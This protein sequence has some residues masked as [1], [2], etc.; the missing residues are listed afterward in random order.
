MLLAALVFLLTYSQAFIAEAG[1]TNNVNDLRCVPYVPEDVGICKEVLEFSEGT[2]I[3]IQGD[4]SWDFLVNR[5]SSLSSLGNVFSMPD[6]CKELATLAGCITHFRPCVLHPETETAI[7]WPVRP[8]RS[9]C[10]DYLQ[11]CR[12]FLEEMEI[13]SSLSIFTPEGFEPYNTTCNEVDI[14]ASNTSFFSATANYTTTSPFGEFTLSCAK[15]LGKGAFSL[16]CEDPLISIEGGC[17]FDCPLPSLSEEQYHSVKLV[18]AVFAWLSVV[19]TTVM[20]LTLFLSNK[21]RVFPAN[22]VI[23]V[24]ISANIEAGALCLATMIGEEEMW[25]GDETISISITIS[26]GGYGRIDDALSLEAKSPLCTFQGFLLLF[27]ILAATFWWFLVALN[28][29][30]QLWVLE[31]VAEKWKHLYTNKLKWLFHI[32]AW[33]LATLFAVVPA[34]ANKIAFSS[35]GTF[36]FVTTENDTQVFFWLFWV[37]PVCFTLAAGTICFV[38]CIAKIARVTIKTK[39]W[40][41]LTS[42]LRVGLFVLVFLITYTFIFAYS[43]H[44]ETSRSVVED[45][46]EDYFSCIVMPAQFGKASSRECELDEDVAKYPLVVLRA[47]GVSCLGLFIFFNFFS[48]D[49]FVLYHKAITSHSLRSSAQRSSRRN[50]KGGKA[51]ALG[52]TSVESVAEAEGRESNGNY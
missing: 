17:G 34:A 10:L 41:L 9:F 50:K 1:W 30:F 36:C 3:F 42:N 12:S 23:M 51:L 5:I 28:M 33:G 24:A 45:G 35:A 26:N 40:E 7:T 47:L 15:P 48:K 8:C 14:W 38:C 46:Y 27:G 19:A 37:V 4:V 6:E 39:R 31:N 21:L 22:L 29:V 44:V 20:V 18:Q 52:A 32:V 11:A 16:T 13:D 43:V 49:W 2:P 25:C